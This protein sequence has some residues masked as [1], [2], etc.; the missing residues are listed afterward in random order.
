ML[1]QQAEWVTTGVTLVTLFS[2]Y[3]AST[4]PR[5]LSPRVIRFAMFAAGVLTTATV[6]RWMGAGE[7]ITQWGRQESL[8]GGWYEE[9]GSYQASATWF[10]AFLLIGFLVWTHRGDRRH[11]PARLVVPCF[12]FGAWVYLNL[13]RV[14]SEHHVDATLEYPIGSLQLGWLFEWGL[15]IGLAAVFRRGTNPSL[16]RLRPSVSRPNRTLHERG[17]RDL[18]SRW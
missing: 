7:E 17:H 6:V 9:R 13:V 14:I 15:L 10:L 3:R 16:R 8:E 4:N 1:K 12:W 2:L 11:P 18:S 5:M